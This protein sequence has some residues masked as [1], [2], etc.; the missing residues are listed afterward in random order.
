M[1]WLSEVFG[2]AVEVVKGCIVEEFVVIC[3]VEMRT[4]LI[5]EEV[6]DWALFIPED[7]STVIYEPFNK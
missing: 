4:D 6:E 2:T 5:R 1:S 7:K 3:D